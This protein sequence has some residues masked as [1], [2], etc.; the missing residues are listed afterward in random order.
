RWRCRVEAKLVQLWFDHRRAV[1]PALVVA[2]VVL[3]ARFGRPEGRRWGYFGHDRVTPVAGD[4]G[5]EC[6]GRF[7]LLLG[8]EEDRRT[9]LR[10]VVGALLVQRGR[11]VRAEEPLKQRLVADD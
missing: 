7:V 3:V 4:L 6:D 10:A 2:E 5:D 8:V 1:A 9:V 11:V